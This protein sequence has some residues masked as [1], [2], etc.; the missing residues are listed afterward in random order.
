MIIETTKLF[1]KCYVF[2]PQSLHLFE[3]IIKTDGSHWF[4]IPIE[5]EVF[6]TRERIRQLLT[7][8]EDSVFC[9]KQITKISD[10]CYVFEPSEIYY[11]NTKLFEYMHEWNTK[12]TNLIDQIEVFQD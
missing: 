10:D 5:A 3:G 4:L 12:Y 7:S 8:K 2:I 6:S 11:I 9:C 1:D